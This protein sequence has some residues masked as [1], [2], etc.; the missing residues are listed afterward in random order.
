MAQSAA[1]GRMIQTKGPFGPP[2]EPRLEVGFHG[3][4]IGVVRRIIVPPQT[5]L[6]DGLSYSL[7]SFTSY[8]FIPDHPAGPRVWSAHLDGLLWWVEQRLAAG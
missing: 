2:D 3:Q 7:P 5:L 1:H 6:E 8:D 4:R